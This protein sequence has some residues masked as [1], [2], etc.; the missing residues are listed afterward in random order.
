MK[1]ESDV[2]GIIKLAISWQT[3]NIFKFYAKEI[4]PNINDKVCKTNF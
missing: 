4:A 1:I 3:Q 2:V